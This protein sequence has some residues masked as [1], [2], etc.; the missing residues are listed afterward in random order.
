MEAAQRLL[1]SIA[2][3]PEAV[4]DYLVALHSS[5]ISDL[6]HALPTVQHHHDA[7]DLVQF[8]VQLSSHRDVMMQIIRL[9]LDK[10]LSSRWATELCMCYM[11]YTDTLMG[12]TDVLADEVQTTVNNVLELLNDALQQGPSNRDATNFQ[13]VLDSIP[14]LVSLGQTSSKTFA[15]ILDAI[16]ALSWS[17]E[18]FTCLLSLCRTISSQLLPRHHEHLQD[19]LSSY[20]PNLSSQTSYSFW[21]DCLLAC[22]DLSGDLEWIRL[23][24]TCIQLVPLTL[25][26]EMDFFLQ[27]LFQHTPSFIERWHQTIDPAELSAWDYTLFLHAL[28]ASQPLFKHVVRDTMYHRLTVS[29]LEAFKHCQT[30]DATVRGMLVHAKPWKGRVLLDLARLW[31]DSSIIS[32]L[33]LVIFQ[34]VAELRQEILMWILTG[35]D[36][37]SEAHIDLFA[38]LL[39]KL[40]SNHA[41]ELQPHI[42]ELQERITHS[43]QSAPT[44]AATRLVE[45]CQPLVFSTPAYYHFLMVFLRKQLVS[46]SPDFAIRHWC[47]ILASPSCTSLQIED[48][49]SCLN[50]ALYLAPCRHIVLA[51][52]ETL[53]DLAPFEAAL[54]HCLAALV[55]VDDK[56]V[57]LHIEN[58]DKHSGFILHQ[59]LDFLMN[60][61]PTSRALALEVR[62][63]ICQLVGRLHCRSF[64]ASF[65]KES[66]RVI[67]TAFYAA[68]A[69]FQSKMMPL[70][71]VLLTQLPPDVVDTAI[72]T[73]ML[74]ESI[75][76]CCTHWTFWCFAQLDRRQLSSLTIAQTEL[77]ARHAVEKYVHWHSTTSLIEQDVHPMAEL[78]IP[79]RKSLRPHDLLTQ[80]LRL[81]K[82]LHLA[83]AMTPDLWHVETWKPVS[84]A[85]LQQLDGLLESQSHVG[86]CQ[87]ILDYLGYLLTEVDETLRSRTVSRV[88]RLFCAHVVSSTKVIQGLLDVAWLEPNRELHLRRVYTI[89]MESQGQNGADDDDDDDADYLLPAPTLASTAAQR[90]AYMSALKQ[91][92]EIITA[93]STDD[94][95]SDDDDLLKLLSVAWNNASL[96]FPNASRAMDSMLRRAKLSLAALLSEFD[97]AWPQVNSFVDICLKVGFTWR[98]EAAVADVSVRM[99][100]FLLDVSST[101]T[102]GFKRRTWPKS[103]EVTLKQ[104]VQAITKHVMR[105]SSVKG[106]AAAST[107]SAQSLIDQQPTPKRKKR[108]L[109]S[110][111]AHIDDWLQD[112]SGDD[113]YAD[114]EDFIV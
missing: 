46:P 72:S 89:L 79:A 65:S 88:Y 97:E 22:F 104:C 42:H 29:L 2:D 99:Q 9:I 60:L 19:L 110:R 109:R 111:H 73:S 3:D 13:A 45:A 11:T 86:L 74:L 107:P 47:L 39:Q 33:V 100:R 83:N 61:S 15:K 102:T 5:E 82:P 44:V 81:W 84:K 54:V 6:V 7:M 23:A 76:N 18:S 49:S 8:L 95:E 16:L 93:N 4:K 58:L 80:L 17:V 108:P 52:L 43:F 41:R 38:Q 98:H 32:D 53:E 63:Q 59:S 50:D 71:C 78:K 64:L 37:S 92:E 25:H 114:L 30:L 68:L 96:S 67:A 34:E 48:I 56:E 70:R 27:T 36:A 69:Q 40:T 35:F 94:G 12:S 87:A 101:I 20:M 103:Q 55:E 112:E 62:N 10:K 21:H 75:D 66:D 57:V 14:T 24:R 51:Y 91:V 77:L 90:V 85:L 31:L 1:D 113:A 105:L 26:R 28:H 106:Q